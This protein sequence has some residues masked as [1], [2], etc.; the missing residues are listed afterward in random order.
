MCINQKPQFC[1]PCVTHTYTH[2]HTHIHTHTHS[3]LTSLLQSSSGTVFH[4]GETDD[5]TRYIA[6]TLLSDVTPD[7]V[8]MKDEIF[9]PL[10]PFVTVED[11]DQA[12][13]F[14]NGR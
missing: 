13:E 6:P 2:T 14:V 9:G 12:I 8:I 1:I 10:L 4:G 3:R 11:V 5:A 7:D